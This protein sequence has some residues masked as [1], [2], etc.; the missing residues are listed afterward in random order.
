MLFLWLWH[1]LG[2][3]KMG[4]GQLPHPRG[5]WDL[6]GMVADG[7]SILRGREEVTAL[8]SWHPACVP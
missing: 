5:S 2:R 1:A 7:L 4:S 3:T 8:D 6:K